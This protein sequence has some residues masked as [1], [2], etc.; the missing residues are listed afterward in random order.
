MAL[1]TGTP[2]GLVS[3]QSDIYIDSAPPIFFQHNDA[4][5]GAGSVGL[6]NAP[7]ANGFY[8]GLSGTTNNPVYQLG[9]IENVQLQGNITMT[10]IRCDTTGDRGAIQKLSYIDITANLKTLLPLATLRQIIRGGAVTTVSGATEQFGIGQPDNSK[11]YYVWMP[12]VYDPEAGDYLA[13]TG[14]RAQFVDSWQLAFA[15][16]QP[17]TIGI[18]I[19]L[20]ADDTKPADQLFASV[21]RADPSA[22]A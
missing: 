20:F 11:Y 3:Q 10:S 14:F 22:I 12:A 21:I 8:W 4:G 17:A 16:G 2:A 7:D 5:T 15:Y 1:V 19:R 18:A 6:L 9:C 13:L